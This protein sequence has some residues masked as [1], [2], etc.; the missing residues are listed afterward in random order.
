MSVE[1][2]VPI[3][4]DASKKHAVRVSLCLKIAIKA[5]SK[6][7]KRDTK[8]ENIQPLQLFIKHVEMHHTRTAKGTIDTDQGSKTSSTQKGKTYPK[9][10]TR[11]SYRSASKAI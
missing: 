6:R 9:T 4:I 2:G 7:K 10:S 8:K 3:P 1:H 5:T 11:P